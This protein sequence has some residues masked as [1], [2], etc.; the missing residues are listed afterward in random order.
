M[1]QSQ[2]YRK[3]IHPLLCIPHHGDTKTEMYVSDSGERQTKQTLE[4]SEQRAV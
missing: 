3:D 4:R 1:E 2:N